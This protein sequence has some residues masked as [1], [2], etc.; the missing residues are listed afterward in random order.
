[1]REL[2]IVA[3]QIQEKRIGTPSPIQDPAWVYPML[4]DRKWADDSDE[5]I[6]PQIEAKVVTRSA[7]RKYK[8]IWLRS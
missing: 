3:Y 5:A 7:R 1:M 4:L 6:I 8:T 2:L